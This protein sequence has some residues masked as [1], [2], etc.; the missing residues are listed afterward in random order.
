[1]GGR[2]H[3]LLVVGKRA[4][5][6]GDI[7]Q[8]K[9]YRRTTASPRGE[10]SEEGTWEQ[11]CAALPMTMLSMAGEQFG[12]GKDGRRRTRSLEEMERMR[13]RRRRSRQILSRGG[14]SA[15]MSECAPASARRHPKP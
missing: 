1:M 6:S 12:M 7:G 10:Q 5:D 9:L 14:R 4:S 8:L 3:R 2:D 13:E 11:G 15:S